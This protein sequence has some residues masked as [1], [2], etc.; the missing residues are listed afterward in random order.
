MTLKKDFILE[1]L[2]DKEI[3]ENWLFKVYKVNKDDVVYIQDNYD[4][5]KRIRD[6]EYF[7]DTWIEYRAKKSFDLTTDINWNLAFLQKRTRNWHVY[8]DIN[9]LYFDNFKKYFL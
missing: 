7:T 6:I 2:K 1:N 4:I 3:P 5:I 9:W 8:V